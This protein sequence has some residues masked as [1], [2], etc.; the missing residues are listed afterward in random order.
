MGSTVATTSHAGTIRYMAPE[1][2]ADPPIYSKACDIFS[3]AI[4][5]NELLTEKRPYESC[6][7]SQI[8]MRIQANHRPNLFDGMEDHGAINL[9]LRQLITKCW[10]EDRLQ[11]PLFSSIS[12]LL[13]QFC[14]SFGADPRDAI[15][16]MFTSQSITSFS[17]DSSGTTDYS[18]MGP[19]MSRLNEEYLR[20]YHSDDLDRAEALESLR[21]EGRQIAQNLSEA[22]K[23][24]NDARQAVQPIKVVRACKAKVTELEE[25]MRKLEQ[26]AEVHTSVLT[27]G[28]A[29]GGEELGSDAVRGNHSV[30]AIGN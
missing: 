2:W 30:T 23:T 7:S 20:A 6:A 11:R 15:R 28:A 4:L 1:V 10:H 27:L 24:L 5:A 13:R 14:Q 26:A 29:I 22:T 12:M 17:P 25:R 19:V 9:D 16:A 18:S 3:F 21:K 8:P